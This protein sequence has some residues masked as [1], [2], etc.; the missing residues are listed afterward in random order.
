MISDNKNS[1]SHNNALKC[2]V[3]SE[4][5][6]AI[7]VFLYGLILASHH[8]IRMI[9]NN[10]WGDEGIVVL[11][12]RMTFSE[13]L[14][15]VACIGHT[16]LHYVFAWICKRLFGESGLVYHFSAA[17]PYFIIIGVT[18]FLIRKWF[19]NKAAFVFITFCSLLDSA[20]TYNLEIRMYAWCQLF[21]LLT[22]IMFY[23]LYLK[24]G[25][26]GKY[27]IFT[28]AF[29][30]GAAY[31]HYY[32]LASIGLM[33]LVFFIYVLRTNAKQVWKVIA[34]GGSVLLLLLPWLIYAR[35]TGGSV[36]FDYHIGAVSWEDCMDF[37]FYSK[38]SS[39]LLT[40]LWVVI[41]AAFIYD[42]GMVNIGKDGGRLKIRFCFKISGLTLRS[43]QLW[44]AGGLIGVFGTI[45]AAQIIS[46]VL[47]PIIVL[48]YLYV[49]YVIIWLIFSICISR[50]KLSYIW[51]PVLIVFVFYHC[52]PVCVRTI[53][54]ELSNNESLKSALESTAPLIDE[55]DYIYT[56][57]LHF[58]WTVGECYYP[59]TPHSLFGQPNLW[60]PAELP[61]L[62][63][64]YEY[65]LF[66]QEPI[67]DAIIQNLSNQ[68]RRAN[69]IVDQGCMGVG[70][71]WIY[72][73]TDEELKE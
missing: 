25:K 19:G 70:N 27:Y 14:H 11:A 51:V 42:I 59:N 22:F 71:M 46:N 34:S 1:N 62:D 4:R 12:S 69:I 29:A 45:A 13:M 64:S 66:L 20:I 16:P 2:I 39:T 8:A 5:S 3:I 23:K 44:I 35:K 18:V 43:T 63:D 61:V 30:V 50:T 37:I 58:V 7:I 15:Y 72:Q 48:R 73:V 28:T 9:D 31:S 54:S 68:G 49:S 47:Y 36:I 53:K 41:A 32:A 26:D 67:S 38:C 56:D 33:Y 55:N 40:L 6:Q 21:I 60:G 24:N 65:W 57:N 10:V 17:L 52:Y